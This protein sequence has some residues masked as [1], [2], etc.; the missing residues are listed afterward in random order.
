MRKASKRLMQVMLMHLVLLPFTPLLNITAIHPYSHPA[1][2]P[3]HRR[4]SETIE[5]HTRLSLF[6]SL[7]LF[8]P[9][10]RQGQTDRHTDSL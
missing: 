6:L 4:A 9:L 1:S 3:S 7:S 2:T 10:V 8:V 5:Y